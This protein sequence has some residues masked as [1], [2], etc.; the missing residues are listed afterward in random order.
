MGSLASTWI[1]KQTGL[2]N[3]KYKWLDLLLEELEWAIKG[4]TQIL[5]RKI[6]GCGHKAKIVV[7]PHPSRRNPLAAV[8]NKKLK[9]LLKPFID[10]LR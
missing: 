3:A 7:L 5:E 6:H 8:L 9:S 2:L 4:E 10:S 1:L